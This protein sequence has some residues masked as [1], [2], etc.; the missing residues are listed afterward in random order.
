MHGSRPTRTRHTQTAMAM[1]RMRV[2]T[3]HKHDGF[4]GS[5]VRLCA[6]L[7]HAAPY[8]AMTHAPHRRTRPRAMC[9]PKRHACS[10]VVRPGHACLVPRTRH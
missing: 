7:A 4:R 5:L 8:G 10:R 1:A 9:A 6:R 2:P 3:T